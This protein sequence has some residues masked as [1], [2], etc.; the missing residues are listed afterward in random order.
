M[1]QPTQNEPVPQSIPPSSLYDIVKSI[2]KEP[3]DKQLWAKLT[4]TIWER[5][6]EKKRVEIRRWAQKQSRW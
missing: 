4:P 1:P 3:V 6:S 2:E 5:L